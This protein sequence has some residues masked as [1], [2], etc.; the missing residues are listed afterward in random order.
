MK[1]EFICSQCGQN[2]VHES[3]F[4]TG[5]ATDRTTGNKI[6]F[7]CCGI[8]D[9]KE[10]KELPIG[11]KTIQYWDGKNIINWPGTLKIN[12]YC[13]NKGRHNIAGKREDIYFKFEGF[14]YHAVQYG[15]MS[16]IT[17]IKKMKS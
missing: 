6:C 15:E 4:S 16:Q 3:D 13:V 7:D 14:N 9:A 17:H 10:L 2:K 5:Y 8:N 1:H 11:K 12:P